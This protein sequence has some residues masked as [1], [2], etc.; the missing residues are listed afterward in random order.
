MRKLFPAAVAAAVIGFTALVLVPSR[1]AAQAITFEDLPAGTAVK[2]QY[3]ARGVIF[4]GDAHI[5]ND[6]HAHSGTRVLRSIS[7]TAEVFTP[8][9]LVMTFTSPGP[10]FSPGPAP[11]SRNGR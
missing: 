10:S 4:P 1:A 7:E 2:A 3:G 9:P 11:L 8:A 5:A 6:P